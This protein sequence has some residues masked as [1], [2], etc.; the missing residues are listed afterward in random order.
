[1]LTVTLP[2]GSKREFEAPVSVADIARI[3]PLVLPKL[4]W[5]VRSMANWWI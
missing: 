5:P 2:D 1:M 4:L 3:L